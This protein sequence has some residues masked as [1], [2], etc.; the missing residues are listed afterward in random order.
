VS[1]FEQLLSSGGDFRSIGNSNAVVAGVG[2][3]PDLSRQLKLVFLELEKE[4]VPSLNARMR[5]I[6]ENK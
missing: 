1:K 2:D 3:Q 6:R 4:D 5:K